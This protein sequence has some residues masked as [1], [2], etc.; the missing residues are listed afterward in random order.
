[1]VDRGEHMAFCINCGCELIDGAKFCNECGKA[2][3]KTEETPKRKVVYEG[4]IHKCPQ[5]GEVLKAFVSN[6]PICEYELRDKK[7]ANSSQKFYQ[8]V[9]TAR[10]L[11]E[12]TNMIRNFPIPN[13][14][15]D[16]IEFMILAS[17]NV[18]G[19][20][21]NE[22]SEA[23]AAKFEQAYQKSQLMFKN[24]DDFEK[25]QHLYNEWHLNVNDEKTRKNRKAIVEIFMRNIA[26]CVGA[27]LIVVC[28]IFDLDSVAIE[29]VVYVVLIVSACN[30]N[31]RTGYPIDYVVAAASGVMT[32]LFSYNLSNE[33]A[34]QLFGGVVLIIVAVK[35]LKNITKNDKQEV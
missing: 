26:A 27:F 34:G 1:M 3:E 18:V 11:S 16:I 15:E 28:A 13:T 17:S 24:D 8:E 32:M 4:E 33:E 30:L 5:C 31:K 10:D 9:K 19:E 2:I 29:L 22:V 7:V 20:D 21:S 35:Y 23:W 14:K 12:K 6:C 25:V